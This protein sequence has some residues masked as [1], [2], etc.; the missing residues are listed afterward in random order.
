LLEE[1]HHNYLR[2]KKKGSVEQIVCIKDIK[3]R[4]QG[5]DRS[6]CCLPLADRWCHLVRKKCYS[7]L[8][9][10]RNFLPKNRES[11]RKEG[12]YSI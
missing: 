9:I 7:Q 10:K 3:G 6:A 5:E 4:Y 11:N 2:R 1:R 8:M 12:V